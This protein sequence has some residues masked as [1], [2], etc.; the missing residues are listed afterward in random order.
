VT[1]AFTT[2]SRYRREDVLRILHLQHRQLQRWENSGLVVQKE[3]YSFQDLVELRKLRDLSSKQMNLA[4]I[5]DTVEAMR[6]VA[7]M[8]SPLLEADAVRKGSR[9]VF[10]HDGAVE[11]PF[12]PQLM[13]DFDGQTVDAH[14]FAPLQSSSVAQLQEMFLRAVQLE[15][16]G[17]LQPALL[18][19]SA[20]LYRQILELNPQHA[21]AC[22]NLGTIHYN[23]GKFLEAEALYRRATVADG[24]Y[25]LAFFD[26]GNVLDE[27]HRLPEAIESYQRA[28]EL[29]PNYADAH[30]NLALAYERQGE[31]RRA[32]RHWMAYARLDP[33][34]PW[35]SH[36][37]GQAK[38]ILGQERLSIIHRGSRPVRSVAG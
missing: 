9:L 10:R 12:S 34:G 31:R 23:Q 14:S 25:A 32:L 35:A 17:A 21:P 20:A 7:G 28:I 8:Q 18:Q 24:E 33:V 38:K 16:A 19:E 4:K 26:L 3:S 5:R 1:L 22:I 2:V 13:F 27:L 15:E 37:R 30:Y 11:D 6:R 36:A 29:V